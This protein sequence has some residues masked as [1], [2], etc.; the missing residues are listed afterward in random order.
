MS[1]ENSS[2]AAASMSMVE[3]SGMSASPEGDT[4]SA[5]AGASRSNESS[6]GASSTTSHFSGNGASSSGDTGSAVVSAASSTV[7]SARGISTAAESVSAKETVASASSGVSG[8]CS[9]S[10]TVGCSGASSVCCSCG[11]GNWVVWYRAS[12]LRPERE[13]GM[14]SMMGTSLMVPRCI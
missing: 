12:S 3:S 8:A 5:S 11:M 9:C 2:E 4:A 6:V 14:G 13:P 7:S 10:G 1:F